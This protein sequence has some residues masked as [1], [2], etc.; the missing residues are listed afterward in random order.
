MTTAVSQRQAVLIFLAFAAA[1]FF[2]ALVRAI[3]ATLAPTLTAELQL[4]SGDLGLLSGAFFLGFSVL[5]LPM[6][7]WLDRVGPRRV[8]VPFLIAAVLGCLAFAVAES[9]Y[10]LLAARLLC[11]AG[12]A[13]CL[14]APLTGYR[15][16]YAPTMQLRANAWMLMTGSLGMLAATMPVQW[17]LPW[18]GWR[19]L[20]VVLAGLILIAIAMLMWNVPTWHSASTTQTPL[21]DGGYAEVG[22]HPYFRALAPLGFFT[23]GGMVAVQTLWAG[24]WLT[25]VVGVEPVEAAS[26]LFMI[27]LTMLFTFWG[28][29][30][31][32]P[33]F[34]KRGW[35]TNRLMAWGIPA[36]FLALLGNLLLG[37]NGGWWSLAL[38]CMASSFVTLSQPALGLAFASHLAGRALSAYNLVLFCGVFVVQWGVGVLVDVFK[39]GGAG[40]VLAFQWAFTVLLLCQ[41]AS[42]IWFLRMTTDNPAP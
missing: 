7:N 14:M 29:G 38:F 18:M 11:G 24:P 42:Y 41:L 19:W 30:V 17:L 26:G 32:N 22:R 35:D 31:L 28:W 1:Y 40:D 21:A 12:F 25:A 33:R 37:A 20:F 36:S 13:A 23:Y 9:F 3:T 27:N 10:G 8:E 2:S 15:R 4:T 39:R 6:G 34:I 16:W 5:Q